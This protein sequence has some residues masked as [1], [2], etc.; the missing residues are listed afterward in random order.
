VSDFQYIEEAAGLAQVVETIDGAQ[1]IYLDTEFESRR[2][3]TTLC[4]VQL[5]VGETIYLI[6]TVAIRD[7]S[8]L[9]E[10]LAKT[11]WV[12]HAGRQDVALLMT[13]CGLKRRPRLFDTQIAWGLCSAE[14]QVSLAYLLAT[15][16]GVRP[17]KGCQTDNWQARPL[18][19]G[20]LRYAAD[21]VAYLPALYDALQK[22]LESVGRFE[23]VPQVCEEVHNPPPEPT[24]MLSLGQFRNLW[25]L[26]GKQRAA[27][28]ALIDWYNDLDRAEARGAPGRKVL[29]SIASRL[30][31]DG[32]T[33]CRI[34]GVPRRFS[35]ARADGLVT[36]MRQAADATPDAPSEAT[37]TPYG[38]FDDLF[39]DAWLQCARAE[40]CATALIAPELGFPQW[41]LKHL[42]AAISNDSDY[43]QAAACFVGWRACLAPAWSAFCE[44]TLG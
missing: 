22:R 16:V 29:L 18:P 17:E 8:V 12:L 34:K 26:T 15:L 7:I 43:A 3:G 21:D 41:L 9:G 28:V 24:T 5:T 6:D 44:A 13:A 35:M 32:R 2:G 20:Q 42:R 37:P 4:L 31:E 19:E 1:R 25:Q 36:L 23:L 27:L 14:H 33:L 10:A 30:P 11:E 39:R 40:V 38:S